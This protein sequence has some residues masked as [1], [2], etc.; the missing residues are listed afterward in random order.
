MSKT[1]ESPT[2]EST[3]WA[4]LDYSLYLVTDRDCLVNRDLYQSI[5]QALLGGVTLVQLREKAVSS[6][7]FLDIALR[8][9]E[10]T[11]RYR[12]PLIINDRLDIALAIDADGLHIGQDDLPLPLARKL[13]GE[14]KI[15]GV[16][17]HTLDE[18]LSAERQGAD[19]LGVGAI[20]PTPTKPDALTVSL[21]QL[22]EIKK[23]IAIPVVAIGG[24]NAEN[25]SDI[26]TTGIDGVSI[27]S[28]ILGKQDIQK[29][30]RDL[31]SKINKN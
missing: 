26:M 23:S 17:A 4:N 25:A 7:E 16:S 29:A 12:I 14:N 1:N 11:T 5:E 8:V 20:Y 28:A 22:A 10:I 19:Y 3:P 6:R 21:K 9:K 18:A 15:I 2:I 30:A 24:I 31:L 27:V 13:F